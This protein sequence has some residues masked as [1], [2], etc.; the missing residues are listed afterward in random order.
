MKN[1]FESTV[2]M[3]SAQGFIKSVAG[4]NKF[5]SV[6]IIDDI[7]YHF[8][9]QFNPA[10]Q[11]FQSNDATLEYDS[12]DQLTTYRDLEGKVGTQ[13]VSINLSNGAR[14]R[15]NLDMPLS[16]ASRVSGSGIWTQN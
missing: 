6:F 12:P 15:G 1:T 14:I 7:Q 9:G 10:V 3:P 16:P 13:D 5:A 2:K 4:G 11:D 8:Q